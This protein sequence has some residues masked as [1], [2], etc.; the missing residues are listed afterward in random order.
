ML[1]DHI[2]PW[3]HIVGIIVGTHSDNSN[4][5]LFGFLMDK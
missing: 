1:T 3:K 5:M 2:S 4:D